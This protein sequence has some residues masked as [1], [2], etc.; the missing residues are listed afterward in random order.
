MESGIYKIISPTG[1]I[2]IGQT[3]DLKNRIRE[4]KLERCFRQKKLF[5]SLKKHGFENHTF[6]VIE[7]CS[8]EKLSEREKY[9]I[10]FFDTFNTDHGMN[11]TIGG[12][13]SYGYKHSEASRKII[14]QKAKDRKRDCFGEKNGFF[15]KKH[16]KE[17]LEKMRN[18]SI[19]TRGPHTKERCE[20]MSKALKGRK[21]SKEEIETNRK[22]HIGVG[23]LILN[24]QT[25]IYYNCA[26]EAA[27][28]V[29]CK[30]YRFRR[31]LSGNYKNNTSFIYA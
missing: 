2:Y 15:G 17:S 5:N 1:K 9:F 31:K 11:L 8:I 10:K 22:S 16:T 18:N 6:E 24:T 23:R 14:S 12:E 21:A 7:F 29:P 3:I 13:G 26:Q 19:K 20:N 30:M 4:Y 28:S 27:N 25:G